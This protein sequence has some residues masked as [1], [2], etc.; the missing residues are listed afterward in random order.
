MKKNLWFFFAFVM[1]FAFFNV[2]AFSQ[3]IE[4]TVMQKNSLSGILAL[5]ANN[6]FYETT[7]TKILNV[8]IEKP[9]RKS[10]LLAG[11]L[12]AVL[13]GAGEMYDGSYLKG[14]IFMAV[15]AAAITTALIYNH[16]GDSQATF[17]QN[18]ANEH[19]DVRKYAYWTAQNLQTLAPDMSSADIQKYQS[20]FLNPFKYP[21]STINWA[22][23][24][25]MEGEIASDPAGGGYTHQLPH[26]GQQY[27]EII[28][29]YN[30]YSKGW[31]QAWVNGTTS[32]NYND[33]PSQ[34]FW[35]MHQ[36]GIAN[37]YYSTGS[38]AVAFIYI[39]HILS[40]ID[41]VWFTY[42][43][44]KNL[45]MNVSFDQQLVPTGLSYVPTLHVAVN[46]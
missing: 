41:A 13:P 6:P 44:N 42:M 31:D 39:N 19:W 29:K 38:T 35:Y 15:E 28:G 8:G 10:E 34:I 24:N 26:F 12:S 40:I 45:R 7:E 18:Y 9:H 11:V 21:N 23:L 43:D 33:I 2:E 25:Q 32:N 36:R 22:T 37:D 4:K 14:A 20:A 3:S 17:F 30:Q 46:F 5:D 27:Y 1:L 16:K